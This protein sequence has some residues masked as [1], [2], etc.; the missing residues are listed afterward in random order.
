MAI[1]ERTLT[2][3]EFLALPE[4]EPA[5]ELW[6]GVVRQKVSPQNQHGLLRAKLG[7]RLNRVGEPFRLGL[8]FTEVRFATDSGS[9]V[10]DVSFYTRERIP[11]LP[12]GRVSNERLGPPDL[13]VEI[14]SPEQSVSLLI[15]KCLWYAEIGVRVTLLVVPN[16]E[17]VFAFRP[18][19]PLRALGGNDRIDPDD[20]LPGFELTVAGLFDL[21][22]PPWARSDQQSAE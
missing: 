1:S 4:E 16:D 17:T 2:L 6:D 5:L 20:V 18:G 21:L 3:E 13:A 12:N 8:V 7:G 9:A 11:L 14:V 15:R 19:A 10:P 22:I